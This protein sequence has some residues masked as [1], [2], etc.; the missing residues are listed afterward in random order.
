MN[1]KNTEVT[2]KNNDNDDMVRYLEFL[3]LYNRYI[4]PLGA[5]IGSIIL[6]VIFYYLYY[7]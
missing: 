7:G 6:C 4:E 5:L 3:V 1:S 2:L